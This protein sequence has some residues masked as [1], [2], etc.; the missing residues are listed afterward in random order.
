M[1]TGM[2]GKSIAPGVCGVRNDRYEHWRAERSGGLAHRLSEGQHTDG[3]FA[4]KRYDGGDHGLS[5]TFKQREP[6]T[7]CQ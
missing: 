5:L 7:R 3:T 2:R 1:T 4:G 6:Q